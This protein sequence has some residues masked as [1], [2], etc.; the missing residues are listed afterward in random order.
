MRAHLA[1]EV[2]VARGVNDVDDQV[3]AVLAG[4]LTADG[5]VL[6]QDGDALFA[7]QI[8]GIHHTVSNFAVIAEHAG[9][10]E[11]GINECGLSVVNVRDDRDVTKLWMGHWGHSPAG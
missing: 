10:F 2:S 9:L 4:A 7:F 8:T 1:A 5:G 3:I 6:G 11:H